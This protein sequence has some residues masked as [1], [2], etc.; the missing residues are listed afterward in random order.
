MH[1][2]IK[3]FKNIIQIVQKEEAN[4]KSNWDKMLIIR[5]SE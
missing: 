2:N 5:E 4:D 1:L 3:W